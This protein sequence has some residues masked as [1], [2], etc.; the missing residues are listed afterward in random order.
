MPKLE[1]QSKWLYLKL[2]EK[3]SI[4]NLTSFEI[5]TDNHRLS[6]NKPVNDSKRADETHIL[7]SRRPAR[8]TTK[9]GQYLPELQVYI[10][11]TIHQP[12]RVLKVNCD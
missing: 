4:K 1:V 3:T 10:W 9:E 7:N 12:G 11:L 8:K 5:T 6:Y 2:G